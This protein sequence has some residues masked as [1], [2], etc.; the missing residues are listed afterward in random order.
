L[1]LA[2]RKGSENKLS[3]EGYVHARATNLHE[4]EDGSFEVALLMGP[5]YYLIEAENRRVAVREAKRI[6]RPNGLIFASAITRYAPIRWT[7]RFEPAS[8]YHLEFAKKVMNTGT[9]KGTVEA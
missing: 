7:A 4:F 2:K 5:L 8:S 1:E 3:L 6:L 9:W